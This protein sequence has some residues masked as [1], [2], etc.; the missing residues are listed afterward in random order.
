MQRVV[1][2]LVALLFCSANASFKVY[3]GTGTGKDQVPANNFVGTA[4]VVFA[5][6]SSRNYISFS[7]STSGF[8]PADV[9]I[10]G[11]ASLPNK[12][13]GILFLSCLVDPCANSFQEEIRAGST[14]FRNN[15]NITFLIDAITHGKAYVNFG[16]AQVRANLVP[17]V[18]A[19]ASAI[20]FSNYKLLP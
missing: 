12:T 6:D 8:V 13:A 9:E 18:T 5:V 15:A 19:S 11:P 7:Y 14:K 10:R 2:L 16:L 4:S 17:A 3:L 1:F 20:W